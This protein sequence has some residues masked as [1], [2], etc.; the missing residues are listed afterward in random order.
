MQN[1]KCDK[2]EKNKQIEKEENEN[3]QGL[4]KYYKAQTSTRCGK[5]SKHIERIEL[6]NARRQRK[7]IV[8][9]TN[10]I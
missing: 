7:N 6:K 8:R 4:K 1:E 10:L 5:K 2:K 3:E 9:S